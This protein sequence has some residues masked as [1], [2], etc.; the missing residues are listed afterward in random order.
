MC[1]TKRLKQRTMREKLR[2][3]EDHSGKFNLQVTGAPERE[4]RNRKTIKHKTEA[5]PHVKGCKS[6]A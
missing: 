5:V 6:S 4:R 2:Y 1:K 3:P